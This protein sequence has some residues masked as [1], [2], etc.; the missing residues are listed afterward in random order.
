MSILSLI[1]H[2]LHWHYTR[3]FVEIFGLWKNTLWFCKEFFSFEVLIK[4]FF[5]P[6]KRLKEEGGGGIAGFFEGFVVTTI[7][8]VIG[9]IMRLFV[10][11]VGLLALGLCTSAGVILIGVWP[12]LPIL[13]AFIFVAGW[14]G[15]LLSFTN[16]SI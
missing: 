2:Y 7:M 12:I 8:R 9:M 16:G 3:A 1:S 5:Q 11:I 14:L 13:V 4:T 15:V 10:L 6:W